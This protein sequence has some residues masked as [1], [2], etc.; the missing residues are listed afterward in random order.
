MKHSDSLETRLSRFT[1][2]TDSG[3]HLWTGARS[4]G[5]GVINWQGRIWVV[6]RLIFSR[7][8]NIQLKTSQFICHTCDT[9]AC[10]NPVHLFLGDA[11][12]NANDKLSKGRP[13]GGGPPRVTEEKR[14][15]IRQL[16]QQKMPWAGICKHAQ[17]ST[18]TIHRVLR[19]TYDAKKM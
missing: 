14:D 3:C 7:L 1:K 16:Y 11:K 18:A 4:R 19:G 5:Y 6:S 17:C 10:I 2:I 13:N 9:P 8:H 15:L 12:T